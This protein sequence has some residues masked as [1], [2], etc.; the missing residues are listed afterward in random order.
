MIEIDGSEGEGGGQMLRTAIS[1]SCITGKPFR[2][3]HIRAGR[4]KPGL[5]RQHQVAVQA[6]A[7]LCGA[8]V[9]GDGLGSTDLTFAPGPVVPGDYSFDI[10]TAGS[11]TMVLQTLIPPLLF[12]SGPSR[13]YLFGGTHVPFSPSWEFLA[14]VYLPTL[15]GLG[16][17]V[18]AQMDR[19]GFYPKGGGKVRAAVRPLQEL[20]PLVVAKRGELVRITGYSAVAN[21]SRSIAERQAA[22]AVAL[23]R[24]KLGTKTPIRIEVREIPSYSPGT[25]IF[26]KAEY[27]SAVAGFSAL[28]VRGKP[29]ETVGSEAAA[30]LLTHHGSSMPVDPRLAD[31][32][33]LFLAQAAGPSAFGTS[34]VSNHLETNL[35]VAQHFL[36]FEASVSGKKD[37]P[38]LVRIVPKK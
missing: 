3:F 29:A 33:V 9:V 7:R 35:T 31:Q 5:K 36:E 16:I 11:T 15:E 26:L 23:L 13:L 22:A 30:E 1:L 34:R 12:A 18:A 17:N 19:V 20:K 28:G 10:G 21:L 2:I 25:F 8:E 37:E 6:A 38:G 4:E 14:E 32:L 27:R 24:D